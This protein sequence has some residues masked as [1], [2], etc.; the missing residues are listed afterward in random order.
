[1]LAGLDWC[2]TCALGSRFWEKKWKTKREVKIRPLLH[3]LSWAFF[4][5]CEVWLVPKPRRELELPAMAAKIRLSPPPPPICFSFLPFLFFVFLLFSLY[6]FSYSPCFFFF[7]GLQL[8][9][10]APPLFSWLFAASCYNFNKW[11][12][13]DGELFSPPFLAPMLQ[14]QL[15]CQQLD[16]PGAPAALVSPYKLAL[17]A[18]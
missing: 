3:F 1:M 17:M 9:T 18:R 13:P 2:Q 6:L 4:K 10:A 12:K 8:H 7:F 5:A 15:H 11:G 14:P 16:W